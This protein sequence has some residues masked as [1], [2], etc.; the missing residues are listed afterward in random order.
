MTATAGFL[1]EPQPSYV[2][3]TAL[4]A[5]FVTELSFFDATMFLAE[6]AAPTAM[7]MTTAT[8]R[9]GHADTNSDSGGSAYSIAFNTTQPFESA[10][11]EQ[12]RLQRQ[13]A[14][15]SQH[16]G[17]T[18]DGFVELLSRLNWRS[19][20]NACVVEVR[21]SID[22]CGLRAGANR[23][24]DQ[25]AVYTSCDGISRDSSVATIRSPDRGSSIENGQP[26][27]SR[28]NRR[29]HQTSLHPEKKVWSPSGG[30]RCSRVH[31]AP[32]RCFYPT[33]AASR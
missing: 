26:G 23:I 13:Y 25:C 21:P 15:Y 19:I 14:A 6:R 5:K 27:W 29:C 2:A 18:T 4:S 9:H 32:P 20:G 12:P 8:Q 10:C 3:H 28:S 22:M 7:H 24:V 30:Q 17:S 11:M 16:A 31:P 1:H 33:R